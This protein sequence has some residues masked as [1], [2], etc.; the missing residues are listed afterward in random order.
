MSRTHCW[1]F[2][3]NNPSE[4]I[5]T[6]IDWDEYKHVQYAIYQEEVGE[7]GTFHYQGYVEFT[8]AKSLKSVRKILPAH[9]SARRGTQKQAID[10]CSKKDETYIGGPYEYG[11]RK[12][13]GQRGDLLEIQ[14]LIDNGATM[15]TIARDFFPTFIQYGN[16]FQ[17]YLDLTR[18]P[19]LDTPE[20]S[21]LPWQQRIL[22]LLNGS[23]RPRTVLWI[24]SDASGQGKTTFKKYIQAQF[25]DSFLDGTLSLQNTLYPYSNQKIIWFDHP[26][27]QPLDAVF[28][29]QLEKLSDGGLITSPKYESRQKTVKAHIVVTTNRPPPHHH[30]PSRLVEF[31]A[32]LVKEELNA[33]GVLTV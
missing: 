27:S 1:C 3:L 16:R 33:E 4:W 32:T 31:N 13:Q 19:T 22:N 14:K 2:T 17:S 9:W 21:I 23:V 11:Q 24:W 26:R 15:E 18:K 25:P 12:Q 29:S 30:L 28:L 6:L 7:S 10:Y 20:I 8:I 5:S